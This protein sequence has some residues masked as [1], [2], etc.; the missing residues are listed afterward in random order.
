M[1]FSLKIDFFNN[2]VSIYTI[3]NIYTI[4]A[5]AKKKKYQEKHLGIHN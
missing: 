3:F 2:Y 5:M 1:I 4:C